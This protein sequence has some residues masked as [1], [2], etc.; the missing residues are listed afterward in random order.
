MNSKDIRDVPGDSTCISEDF[1]CITS[2]FKEVQ[3]RLK[4]FQ[5]VSRDFRRCRGASVDFRSVLGGFN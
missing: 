4:R 3:R 5:G 2:V 1:M